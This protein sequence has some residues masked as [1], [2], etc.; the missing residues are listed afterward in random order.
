M[1]SEELQL[2]TIKEVIFLLLHTS[3]NLQSTAA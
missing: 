3:P 2:E 1:N